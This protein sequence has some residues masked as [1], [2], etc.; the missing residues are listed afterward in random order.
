MFSDRHRTARRLKGASINVVMAVVFCSGLAAALPVE[1]QDLDWAKRAGGTS[2]DRAWGIVTD[3]AGNSYVTGEL[4]GTATFGP[5]EPSETMLTS[6]G[7]NDVFVAK[8]DSS[9]ALVWARRAGG[10]GFDVGNGIATDAA[11]SSYVTGFVQGTATFGAGEAN[12][13]TLTGGGSFVAKYDSSGDVIW[14]KNAGG[15]A[16]GL[17]IATDAGGNSY[18]TGWLQGAVTFGAGEASETTLTSA[19]FQD[20]FVA[21]YDSNGALV[22]AK[23][24]GGAGSEQG[25]GI[26]A[27][28]SG[29][30]YVTGYFHGAATF[31]G[32][33]ANETTLTS[34]G[35]NDIF[36]AKYD[37]SGAL[38]WA[39]R[40]GGTVND[41]GHGI[42]TDSAGNSYVTG[43]FSGTAT[44]GPGE[45]SQTTL[46]S[47]GGPDIFVAKYNPN[48]ALVWAKRTGGSVNVA[49][50]GRDIATDGTG[51]SYVTGLFSGTA[52]FGL[53]GANATTLTSAGGADFFI[54]KYDPSGA[55]VWARRAGGINFDVGAGIATDGAGNRYV[56]GFFSGTATFGPGEANETVLTSVGNDDI[57][58]PG[59][60]AWSTATATGSPMAR[61]TV[62]QWL[63]RTKRT[64]TVTATATPA[65][66]MTTTTRWRMAATTAR[67]MRI[68]IRRTPMAT[69]PGTSATPISTAT[70]F[71]TTPICACQQLRARWLTATAARSAISARATTSGRTTAPMCR[72]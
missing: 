26:V 43:F 9:G 55:L 39:K 13:T 7:S 54:A 24:A 65:T 38:V 45:A 57:S 35:N 4:H 5:G 34:A 70:G 50:G 69:A 52:T 8:Y 40:A 14:A 21:K 56:S 10:T 48:G 15:S 28:S 33:E 11:G 47:A 66:S 30:S 46:T 20:V 29:N 68:R 22:W 59:T 71:R 3:S 41:Q 37:S 2:L 51:N 1:A 27:D 6:A 16:S 25:Q 44:F 23:R 58:S 49:E 67:S 63:I 42:A 64:P 17:G 60:P 72:A 62:R 12:E 36:V 18:V 53:G 31:G 61:T 19:A 32:G